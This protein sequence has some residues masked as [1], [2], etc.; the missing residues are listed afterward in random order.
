MILQ[1]MSTFV[2]KHILLSKII[3]QL[4]FDDLQQFVCVIHIDQESWKIVCLYKFPDLYKQRPDNMSWFQYYVYLL[5]KMTIGPDQI[6]ENTGI[7]RWIYQGQIHRGCGL[8][9]VV[10]DQKGCQWWDHGVMQSQCHHKH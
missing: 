7:K 2:D 9:A 5:Y 3:P 6:D 1:D 8:P 10:I 4:S